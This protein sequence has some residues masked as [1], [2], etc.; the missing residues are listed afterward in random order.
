MHGSRD[1]SI[2]YTRKKSR[3]LST[4]R[5]GEPCTGGLGEAAFLTCIVWWLFSL[6]QPSFCWGWSTADYSIAFHTR[7][8]PLDC[9]HIVFKFFVPIVITHLLVSSHS[10]CNRHSLCTDF[11]GGPSGLCRRSSWERSPRKLSEPSFC[12]N[13]CQ[14]PRLRISSQCFHWFVFAHLISFSRFSV[15]RYM[16]SSRV[17]TLSFA[18]IHLLSQLFPSSTPIL[19]PP[20]LVSTTKAFKTSLVCASHTF[21]VVASSTKVVSLSGLRS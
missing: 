6:S 19:H 3:A 2:S 17:H 18:H 5:R 15:L 4:G 13:A 10:W 20:K 9:R 11:I 21:L 8:W 12:F 16:S 1:G 14:T 7:I